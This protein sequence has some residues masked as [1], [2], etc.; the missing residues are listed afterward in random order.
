M[1]RCTV[2]VLD[3]ITPA[4][5]FISIMHANNEVGTLQPI[6]EI[7]YAVKQHVQQHNLSRILLHT[8]ASQS[9]G[10][11]RVN[12][13]ELG[14]DFLTIAGHKLYA[15]KGI[16]A[17]YIRTGTPLPEVLIHGA[18]HERGRR[19]GTENVAFDVALGKACELI[20][21]HQKQYEEHLRSNKQFLLELLQTRCQQSGIS[22]QVN[23]HPKFV[24]PNT[25]SI[26]FKDVSATQLLQSTWLSLSTGTRCYLV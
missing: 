2:D 11:V 13:D 12:V 14:V 24:L 6:A 23:G 25:L 19:A 7:S 16:G 21:D 17:L 15:P 18:S 9:I 4:T 5:F 20:H 1:I 22:F 3:A 8:D 10:K 26:S